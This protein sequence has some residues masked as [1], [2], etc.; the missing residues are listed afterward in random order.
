MI[1]ALVLAAGFSRRFGSDKRFHRRSHYA[2]PMVIETLSS[3]VGEFDPCFVVVRTEDD[4]LME[5]VNQEFS[6]RVGVLRSDKSHLGMGASLAEGVRQIV[7][8]RDLRALFVGLGDMPCVSRE[9]LTTLH[10]AM[11]ENRDSLIR[12]EFE[13]TPGHPV[14]FGSRYFR[15]LGELFGDRGA[16]SLLQ[17]HARE[18]SLVP[19]QDPG[20]CLDFD[21]HP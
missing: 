1:G 18:V 4:T 16:V 2:P 7:E 6:S 21:L 13:G 17:R 15:E 14:G 10:W 19:V 20:V 9:T 8:G 5:L 11:E 12:P 3:Y